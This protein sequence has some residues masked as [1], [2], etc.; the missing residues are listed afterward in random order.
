MKIKNGYK[1][2]FAN[3]K[4]SNKVLVY[5]ISVWLVFS[6]VLFLSS[7]KTLSIIIKSNELREIVDLFLDTVKKIIT[8]G[9][10]DG[11]QIG[12]SFEVATKNFFNFISGISVKV[13]VVLTVCIVLSIVR[14]FFTSLCDYVIAVNTNEHMSSMRHAGFFNTLWEN[15]SKSV[16]FSLFKSLALFVCNLI[17]VTVLIFIFLK[18]I[19]VFTIFTLSFILLIS[20]IFVALRLTFT[21]MILPKMVCEGKGVFKSF[22]ECFKEITL[23][24]FLERFFS[25]FYMC[26][27]SYVITVASALFTFF[28]SL[29][30]TIPVFSV[31]FIALRFVDYYEINLKKFYCT[32]DEIVVPK[33]LRKNDENLLNEIDI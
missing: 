5:K 18:T 2:A 12:N 6:I 9:E 4:L 17:M 1:I 8:F 28:V 14:S 33:E 3:K 16:K 20:L 26:F 19:K 29:L 25:Y 21:G 23:P 11:E 10:F 30:I 22:V 31:M 32:F 13:I 24:T 15:L 27:I 7:F